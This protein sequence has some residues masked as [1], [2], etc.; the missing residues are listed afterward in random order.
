MTPKLSTNFH[1]EIL[2]EGINTLSTRF[3]GLFRREAKDEGTGHSVVDAGLLEESNAEQT[4]IQSTSAVGFGVHEGR[5]L[6]SMQ[7]K[8]VFAGCFALLDA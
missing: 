8:L 3:S 2:N 1:Q 6:Q 7:M 4:F 5:K